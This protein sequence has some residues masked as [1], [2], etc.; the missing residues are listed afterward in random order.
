MLLRALL[1]IMHFR[2]KQLD[3][4]R[5]WKMVFKTRI[6][7]SFYRIFQQSTIFQQWIWVSSLQSLLLVQPQL[8][9]VSMAPSINTLIS[10]TF[11]Q[12][13]LQWWN[14]SWRWNARKC[15]VHDSAEFWAHNNKQHIQHCYNFGLNKLKKME[16]LFYFSI[17]EEGF[18]TYAS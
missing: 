1:R 14:K 18:Q 4:S 3:N 10:D 15:T 5:Q 9:L 16:F 17:T 2:D 11:L 12:D 7:F 8:D 13:K 6:L